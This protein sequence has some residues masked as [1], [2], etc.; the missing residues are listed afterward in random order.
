MRRLRE[1]VADPGLGVGDAV[2]A[3]IAGAGLIEAYEAERTIEAQGRIENLQEL[4]GVAREYETRAEE[5]TLTGFLQEISLVADADAVDQEGGKV[6]LMTL[7]NAKGLEFDA[8]FVMGMEQ[9]LFPHIRSIEEANLEEERRLCYVAITRARKQLTVTYTRQRTLFGA[10]GM[11][12]PSQ[13]LDEIPAALAQHERAARQSGYG[14]GYGSQQ[15]SGWGSSSATQRGWGARQGGGG[16]SGFA[17][18]STPPPTVRAPREDVPDLAVGD[19]V[20][21]EQLGEGIVI[22]VDRGGQV[23]VRFEA[24]GS[25]RRLLLAYAPLARV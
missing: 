9:N 3:V 13:F 5:P 8:V 22:G 23:V 18:P 12:L 21:H 10:R 16:G 17:A 15:G 11:N 24:D 25:E 7:H 4:V 2:E 1:R 19:N 6:T 14:G 20:R